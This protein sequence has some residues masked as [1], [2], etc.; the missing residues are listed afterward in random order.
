MSETTRRI[1]Y[2][3]SQQKPTLSCPAKKIGSL[4]LLALTSKL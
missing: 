3:T 4:C 2:H 1:E